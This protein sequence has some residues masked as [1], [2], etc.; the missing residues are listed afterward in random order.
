[1]SVWTVKVFL[2]KK[3]ENKKQDKELKFVKEAS[4]SGLYFK[5]TVRKEQR[6]TW[7]LGTRKEL[8]TKHQ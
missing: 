5:A 8:N 6:R 4:P 7:L 3:R 1:M 2:E